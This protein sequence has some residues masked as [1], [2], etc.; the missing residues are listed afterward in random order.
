[1]PLQRDQSSGRAD[2]EQVVRIGEEADPRND[3]G[4]SVKLACRRFVQKVDDRLAAWSL[5]ADL[6][7]AG[8]RPKQR[9][10]S[11][12]RREHAPLLLVRVNP[13]SSE[14]ERYANTTRTLGY[15]SS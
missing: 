4:T 9:E 6:V 3:N 7:R 13:R 8:W 12:W 14:S 5:V 1:V 10:L 2:D 15:L 11:P